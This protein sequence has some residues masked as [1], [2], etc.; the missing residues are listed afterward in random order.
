M[1]SIDPCHLIHSLLMGCTF[2]SVKMYFSSDCIGKLV[3]FYGN[4]QYK[5]FFFIQCFPYVEKIDPS[6]IVQSYTS[7]NVHVPYQTPV[8][9]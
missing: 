7:I 1:Y 2:T 4:L 6:I 5:Q 3:F 8:K 9:R